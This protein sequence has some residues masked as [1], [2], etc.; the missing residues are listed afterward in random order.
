MEGH[1]QELTP[2]GHRISDI[3]WEQGLGDGQEL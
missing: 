1:L 3:G 2:E